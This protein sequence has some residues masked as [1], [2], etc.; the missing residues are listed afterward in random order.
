MKPRHSLTIQRLFAAV[1][2]TASTIAI[3]DAATVDFND[4]SLPPDSYHDGRPSSNPPAGTYDGTFVSGGVS[5]HN[6]VT[7]TPDYSYF[8][9][10]AVSNRTQTPPAPGTYPE[11]NFA[12]AYQFS[13]S[14]GGGGNYGLVY[15]NGFN[16]RPLVL[17][18]GTSPVS[19][20]VTNTNYSILS[21]RDGDGFAKKFGGTAGNDEDF[22]L[23][24]IQGLDSASQP[25]GAPVLFYLG[26]FL[27][28]NT[29]IVDTWQTLDLT[30]LA[31]AAQLG[32]SLTSSD[33][34]PIYGMNTPAFF[35]MDNLV[36]TAVPEPGTWFVAATVFACFLFSQR[37]FK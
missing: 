34:D 14:A 19:M 12:P 26:N 2:L 31:G 9:G 21:M 25:V 30:P 16:D 1:I 3:S 5:F 37:R 8:A 35:A 10:W 15:L 17:P 6:S 29:T 4:F 33:N 28:S 23:L 7:V 32:F 13:V 27:G 22:F 18:N 24:T 20:Q 11:G 36:L